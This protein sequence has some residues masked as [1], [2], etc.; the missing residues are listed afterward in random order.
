VSRGFP[1]CSCK[2]YTYHSGCICFCPNLC[3]Q[4]L[5]TCSPGEGPGSSSPP[6]GNLHTTSSSLRKGSEKKVTNWQGHSNHILLSRWCT[7]TI[8]T[9]LKD[10]IL[11]H[12]IIMGWEW[13]LPFHKHLK[14]LVLIHWFLSRVE[15]KSDPRI[16]LELSSSHPSPTSVNKDVHPEYMARKK[17][18]GVGSF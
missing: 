6:G 2:C 10:T 14:P 1:L 3:E 13:A 8:I 15:Q 12:S 16:N 9:G 18:G 7:L 11:S 17:R 5:C 4:P